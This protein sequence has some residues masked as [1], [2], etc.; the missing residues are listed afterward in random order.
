MLLQASA[1]AGVIVHVYANSDTDPAAR[2]SIGQVTIGALTDREKLGEFLS[3]IPVCGFES[4][5]IDCDLIRQASRSHAPSVRFVP[6]LETMQ[7][8]SEKLEQKRILQSLGI[9][10]A[11]FSEG[12]SGHVTEAEIDAW[13]DSLKLKFGASFVVKW[14]KYGYDGRGVILVNDESSLKKAKGSCKVALVR[15]VKL[16]AEAR[17]SFVRELAIIGCHST[18]GDFVT[19]PLVISEQEHGICRRVKGPAVSLGVNARF[20]TLAVQYAEKIAKSLP[21]HGSFGVELFETAEGD[22]WVN[23]IA[24][25][26]HNS[27]HYSQ[28]ACK[29]D[30]FENHL[31][32]MSGQMLPSPSSKPFFAMLNLLGPHGLQGKVFRRKSRASRSGREMT[33]HW[34]NK[35]EIFPGRKL[36]HLNC[37]ADTREQLTSRIALMDNYEVRW[38]QRLQRT[39]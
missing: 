3:E 14:S 32:A 27:G 11:P 37:V 13:F 1:Q 18:N 21:L 39:Q 5:L 35:D 30:Q 22:L 7:R 29:T 9:P 26:V 28:D 8:L 15:G 20:E 2:E 25:R 36:G 34:Y 23:E 4:E 10:S 38:T 12:P 16:Y 33:L 19:Y 24:P 6:S 17:V 31:R